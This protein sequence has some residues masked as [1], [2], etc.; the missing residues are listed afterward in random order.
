M[1]MNLNDVYQKFPT[2]QS[3]LQVLEHVKWNGDPICPYCNSKRFTAV[4][5]SF[6]YHCNS[7]NTSF[8]VTVGTLFQDS[9]LDLQKWFYAIYLLSNQTK[10]YSCRKLAAEV[11][12]SKDASWYVMHR[13]QNGIP[14]NQLFLDQI[15]RIVNE[16]G[17]HP[18]EEKNDLRTAV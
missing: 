3:C 4:K 13:I 18:V 15:I 6:R 1:V 12:M 7:C 5:N 10:K 8:S 2:K 14:K 9:K 11:K 17:A 16:T